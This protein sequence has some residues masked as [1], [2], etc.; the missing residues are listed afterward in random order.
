MNKENHIKIK[1]SAKKKNCLE[2]AQC[3]E[4]ELYRLGKQEWAHLS[5]AT[6]L[7]GAENV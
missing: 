1:Y 7:Q 2:Q 4:S 3:S 6:S 5:T